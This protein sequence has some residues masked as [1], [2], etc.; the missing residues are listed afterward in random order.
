MREVGIILLK[1]TV[2]Y[3]FLYE[4]TAETL[5]ELI[6]ENVKIKKPP[7]CLLNYSAEVVSYFP[8]QSKYLSSSTNIEE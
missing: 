5:L 4:D 7:F 3:S 6:S 1:L 8:V 2:L